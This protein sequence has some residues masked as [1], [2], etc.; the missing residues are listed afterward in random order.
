MVC[1]N[2]ARDPW[3]GNSQEASRQGRLLPDS[4]EETTPHGGPSSRCAVVLIISEQVTLGRIGD[5]MSRGRIVAVT[6]RASKEFVAPT[7][8][9]HSSGR[10]RSSWRDRGFDVAVQGVA[11]GNQRRAIS[12]QLSQARWFYGTLG[13]VIG[14]VGTAGLTSS[15]KRCA[16]VDGRRLLLCSFL[17][18]CLLP[19]STS[20][21]PSGVQT[22][23][24][25]VA[26][27]TLCWIACVGRAFGTD[28]FQTGLSCKTSR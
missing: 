14:R 23:C 3:R 21:F 20:S 16:E 4:L 9:Q 22:Q 10:Q 27:G 8:S 1:R 17:G 15:S 24:S 7:C 12:G 6:S 13:S 26:R 11:G 25:T 5:N 18:A 28:K 19:L 2:I